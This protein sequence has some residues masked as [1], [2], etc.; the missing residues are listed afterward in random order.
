MCRYRQS[1][2]GKQAISGVIIDRVC[3]CWKTTG[4]QELLLSL[5]GSYFFPFE[6]QQC[7]GKGASAAE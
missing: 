3:S 4:I 7:S 5:N 1:I 2:K 6:V